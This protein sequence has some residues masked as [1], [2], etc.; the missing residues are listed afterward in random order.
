MYINIKNP[1]RAKEQLK[2]LEETAQAAKSDS[3]NNDF[4]YTQANYYY[5]FGM[6]SQGDA[7]FKKLIEQYKR[8]SGRMLQNPHKHC[9]QSK[10]RRTGGPHL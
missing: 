10:Q 6:N 9:P 4:L 1:A 3:L 2:K 7:A 5:T 8:Q